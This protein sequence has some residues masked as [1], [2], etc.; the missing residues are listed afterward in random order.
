[1]T[2]RMLEAFLKKWGYEPV[3]VNDGREA[4]QLLQ[5][6]DAPR[7][8]ILDWMMPGMDGVF[9]CNEVRKRQIQPY[10]Y[11]I[12]L[13]AKERKEDVIA[14]LEAG[15]DDFL[16]KPFDPYEL[17]ARLRGGERVVHLQ[18]QLFA[19]RDALQEQA[20]HDPLTALLNRP[21]C[22]EILQQ[23]L[24][25]AKREGKPIGVIMIDLDHFKRIN[26]SCGHL[27]GD[28]VLVEVARRMRASVR[29]YDVV[30]RY[31]GEEFLV[32]LPGCDDT[33]AVN[34]AERLRDAMA[35][36]PI[37]VPDRPL[38]ITLSL[39]VACTQIPDE[40]DLRKL[41]SAADKALYRAKMLGR[42]R[43]ELAP[44]LL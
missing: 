3:S 25:R 7:L 36:S 35:G 38:I 30:G 13:T 11:I 26:D 21:A 34:Q 33:S 2:R 24:T 39:G 22:L 6:P 28:L 40:G 43:V 42:N 15:A 31:G 14:G 41:L 1:V 20:T 10:I 32:V 17:K 19:A 37:G 16:T 18:R 44:A 12:L 4:W 27:I 5:R 23:E 9:V 29:S 8:A